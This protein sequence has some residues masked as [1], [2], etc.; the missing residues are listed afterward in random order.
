VGKFADAAAEFKTITPYSPD[1]YEG[2]Y[3]LGLSEL[4]AG[5][6]ADAL[7]DFEELEKHDTLSLHS[8]DIPYQKGRCLYY[9]GRYNDAIVVLSSY[10]ESQDDT[11]KKAS[12]LY[13][14]GESLYA[15]GNYDLALQ[16]YETIVTQYPK[17]PKYPPA[18]YRIDLIKQKKGEEEL[19]SIIKWTHEEL[20]KNLE[21]YETREKN[22][23]QMLADYQ[24]RI[25]EMQGQT[26]NEETLT[27]L[28]YA[29][30]RIAELEASLD[31]ANAAASSAS[32][33]ANAEYKARLVLLRKQTQNLIEL[34]TARAGGQK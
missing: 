29:L 26:T 5:N 30:D 12:A 11:N 24:K 31:A 19:L 15:L 32:A 2:L 34:L 23:D 18:S 13:W 1:F 21:D 14:A 7:S 25:R 20:L 4:S 9:L 3:W 33:S 6:Y 22:Y 17:S 27:Q 28:R 16:M 8:K 10:A